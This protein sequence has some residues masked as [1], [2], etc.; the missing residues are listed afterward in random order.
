M[1]CFGGFVTDCHERHEDELTAPDANRTLA[2]FGLP[3]VPLK[4][5]SVHPP[6]A[7]AAKALQPRDARKLPRLAFFGLGA[8]QD[9]LAINPLE[10]RRALLHQLQPLA[11][12]EQAE[13]ECDLGL[14]IG[15]C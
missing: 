6:A 12:H 8:A 15:S 7:S 10:N 4:L 3:K 1:V 14:A 2:F 11:A 5:V 9:I 13:M